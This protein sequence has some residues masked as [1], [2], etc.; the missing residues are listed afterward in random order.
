MSS[1]R[2]G[3]SSGG[4][5]GNRGNPSPNKM[6]LQYILNQQT[7]SGSASA[8]QGRNPGSR[9]SRK[10]ESSKKSGSSKRRGGSTSHPHA[11]EDEIQP[12]VVQSQQVRAPAS[13]SGAYGAGASASG[14]VPLDSPFA[15]QPCPKCNALITQKH[16]HRHLSKCGEYTCDHPG[17]S[18]KANMTSKLNTHKRVHRKDFV[19]MLCGAKFNRKNLLTK[20]QRESCPQR[21]SLEDSRQ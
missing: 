13:S 20:H 8:N 6:E 9:C 10:T 1:R 17:C 4:G 19:C 11:S 12:N 3:S 14:M 15:R 21:I 18:Y 16:M 2:N 5:G 7:S